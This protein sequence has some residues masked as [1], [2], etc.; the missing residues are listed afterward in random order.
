[1]LSLAEGDAILSGE[2]AILS[3]G[4]ILRGMPS[5]WGAILRGVKG[6]SVKGRGFH[7]GDAMKGGAMKKVL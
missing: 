2:G 1:M 7:E 4:A 6:A 3:G 5:L